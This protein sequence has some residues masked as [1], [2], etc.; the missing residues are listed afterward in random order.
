MRFSC[1]GRFSPDGWDATL[2]PDFRQTGHCDEPYTKIMSGEPSIILSFIFVVCKE[3]PAAVLRPI[4]PGKSARRRR[5][6]QILIG[7]SYRID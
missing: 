1:G 7:S 6:A 5:N 4:R 3:S 2:P